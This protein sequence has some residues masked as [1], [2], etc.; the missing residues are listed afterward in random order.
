M[1]V[2]M[3]FWLLGVMF[4]LFATQAAAQDKEGSIDFDKVFLVVALEHLDS[5]NYELA[6]QF[7]KGCANNGES[8]CQFWLGLMHANGQG[9]PQDYSQAVAWYRLAA[10]RSHA[11]AQYNLGVLYDRGNGVPQD[12]SEA[13]RLYSLAAEQG[14]SSAQNNLGV[15]YLRG[16]GVIQD[17]VAAHKWFNLSAAQGSEA[18]RNNRDVVA[19][20]MT[21]ADIAQAQRLAREWL[22]KNQE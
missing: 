14:D 22:K 2:K 11:V 20:K 13:S 8:E 9:V 12:Y 19:S 16:D 17:Y 5:G 7:L 18:A 3:V 1:R 6:L 15:M 10:G 4:L 21:P